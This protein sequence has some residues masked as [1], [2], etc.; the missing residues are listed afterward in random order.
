MNLLLTIIFLGLLIFL[1]H[2]FNLLFDRTRIP[3]VLLL[4]LIGIVLGPVTNLV[5]PAFFGQMGPVFTT[6]TLI[7]I[8]FESGSDLNLKAVRNSIGS[9][10]LLTLINFALT[11]VVTTFI[12]K[13]ALSLDTLS[14]IFIGAIIGGT[15][16]AVVIP[17]VKQLRMGERIRSVL[18]LESAFS[19][20]LCL[21]VGLAV[22][23]GMFQGE[24]SI[25]S[26]LNTMWTALLFA[27]L[28]G[29]L[30][31]VL[32][33]GIIHQ[34]RG[35][36]NSMFI[37]LAFAFILYGVVELMGFNGG[38]SVLSFGI[39]LGNAGL[40]HQNKWVSKYLP[41]ETSGFTASEKDFFA[42]IVFIVQTY[43]FVYVGISIHFGS[44][45][46]LATSIILILSILFLRIPVTQIMFRG[47]DVG[48]VDRSIMSV[49]TPKGMVPAVLASIPLQR[50]LSHGQVIQ[51]TGFSVV[52]FSILICSILVSILY[53]K[54]IPPKSSPALEAVREQLDEQ[55]YTSTPTHEGHTESAG[56]SQRDH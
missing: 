34:L 27:I 54:P 28:L 44:W 8:L 18:I 30:S 46:V 45:T 51:D 42:E 12:G 1:A 11:V 6:I 39:F 49:M 41:F 9:A 7:I 26:M 21:V 33:S 43:F 13:Y 37:N 38:I 32:W 52:F 5:T 53:R 19:D 14:A 16:S 47:P 40:I 24:I 2:A 17:M 25:I 35:I 20:V 56:E 36:K 48:K 31:G 10:S 55:S 4:L 23:D 3:N 50:G 29:L 22:L 15:S